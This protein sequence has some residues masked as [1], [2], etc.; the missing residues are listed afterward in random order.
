MPNIKKAAAVTTLDILS[1]NKNNNVP[2]TPNTTPPKC[3]KALVNSF[4][5]VFVI[6][7]PLNAM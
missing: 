6:T 2:I 5:S 3:V 7:P 1:V 4:L